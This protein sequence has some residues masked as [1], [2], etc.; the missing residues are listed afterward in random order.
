MNVICFIII[1][2][3]LREGIITNANVTTADEVQ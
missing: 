1:I 3:H 2:I